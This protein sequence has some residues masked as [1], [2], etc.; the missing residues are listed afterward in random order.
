[1]QTQG[2]NF[3]YPEEYRFFLE[4]FDNCQSSG[5]VKVTQ[6]PTEKFDSLVFKSTGQYP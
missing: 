1:M 2:K 3:K 4:Y 6:E 5:S